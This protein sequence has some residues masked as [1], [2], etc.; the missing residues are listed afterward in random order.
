M[1]PSGGWEATLSLRAQ[2][3]GVT[4]TLPQG[5]KHQLALTFP[6][7]LFLSFI[8]SFFDIDLLSPSLGFKNYELLFACVKK[9]I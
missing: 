8:L 5:T 1:E 6:D 7:H 9:R 2:A 4:G 3:W